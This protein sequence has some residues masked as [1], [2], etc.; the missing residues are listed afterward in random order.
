MGG[1]ALFIALGASAISAYLYTELQKFRG[2]TSTML[3]SSTTELKSGVQSDLESVKSGVQSDLESVKSGILTDFETIKGEVSGLDSKLQSVSESLQAVTGELESTSEELKGKLAQLDS[4]L[5]SKTKSAVTRV[6]SSTASAVQELTSKTE[7]EIS[8]LA[9]EVTASQEALKQEVAAKL[10]DVEQTVVKLGDDVSSTREIA[11]RGQREW[12]LAEV[13]YLLRTAGYR[14]TLAGDTK[15]SVLALRAASD[16]L[17]DLGDSQYSPVRAQIADEVAELRQVGTP[18]IE[19][20]AFELQKLSRRADTLPLPPSELAKAIEQVKEDPSTLDA[21]DMAGQLFQSLKDMVKIEKSDGTPL[22]RPG[23]PTREQLTASEGLRLNLQGA[24]LSAL[25]R[26]QETYTMQM[27]SAEKYVRE[28]YDQDDELT[29]A[30]L[31][32]LAVLKAQKIVPSVSKLGKA[33][34]LFN[35]IHSK[36]GEN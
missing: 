6:A 2:Q 9:N 20:V 4:D 28:N 34:I 5:Q 32:D 27:E 12:M 8:S 14:V 7:T 17:H 18:D 30:Y 3:E 11:T 24:R 23:K 35:E 33:L 16:R 21:K 22:I 29:K 31:E 19:G 13:E 26:D 36:R 10:T 15:S 25:R 1:L